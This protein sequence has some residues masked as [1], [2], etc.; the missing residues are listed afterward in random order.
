[1]SLKKEVNNYYSKKSDTSF[2]TLK[3]LLTMN[4]FRSFVKSYS[5]LWIY[6]HCENTLKA[7]YECWRRGIFRKIN[8][9]SESQIG[10]R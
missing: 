7:L 10:M 4:A 9:K 3:L 1:M 6:K 8:D 2:K 5:L